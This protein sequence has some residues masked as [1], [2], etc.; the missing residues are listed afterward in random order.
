MTYFLHTNGRGYP[1]SLGCFPIKEEVLPLKLEGARGEGSLYIG[2]KA[3]FITDG[4]GAIPTHALHNGKNPLTYI[5]E[6]KRYDLGEIY[7]LENVAYIPTLHTEQLIM[8]LIELEQNNK[9]ALATLT[10]RMEDME[11]LMTSRPLF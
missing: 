2:G 1:L 10:S 9:Q 8:L 6:D 3:C 7:C 11:Q 4:I 5:E